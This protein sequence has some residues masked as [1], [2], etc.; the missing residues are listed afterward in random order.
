MS[1]VTRFI[2]PA[3]TLTALLAL[4]LTLAPSFAGVADANTPAAPA[5][6]EQPLLS[7]ISQF[8]TIQGAAAAMT[9]TAVIVSLLFV[10][11]IVAVV[12]TLFAGREVRY[13]S[14]E[15]RAS[16]LYCFALGLVAFTSFVI[17]AIVFSY[18]VPYIV[19]V[20]L[21]A[22]LGVFAILTKVYGMISIFHAVGSMVAG[23][24]TRAQLD[25]RR[26]FRGDLAMVI[27][28]VVVLGA[29]RLIPVAGTIIWSLA[30]VF[31]IGTALATRFGRRD[32]A[33]L[34]WRPAHA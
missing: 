23:S 9:K 1:R 10:W 25:Q 29:I 8:T 4:V 19:G 17:T 3:T 2:V 22:A 16:A 14:V 21:L 24:R 26:W 28:G 5:R 34:A 6:A 33:F 31:G 11:I 32:P 30:S 15:V 20:P 13:S 18:L 27:A 12:V 7:Q